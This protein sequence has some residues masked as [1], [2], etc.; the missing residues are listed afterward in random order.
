MVRVAERQ[1]MVASG[2]YEPYYTDERMW[3]NDNSSYTDDQIKAM[4]KWQYT[5]FANTHKGFPKEWK[6]QKKKPSPTPPQPVIDC[7]F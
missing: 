1:V 7:P 5:G 6:L 2:K 4:W 3:M